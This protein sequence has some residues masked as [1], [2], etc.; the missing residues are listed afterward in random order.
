MGHTTQYVFSIIHK[1]IGFNKRFHASAPFH[2]FIAGNLDIIIKFYFVLSLVRIYTGNLIGKPPWRDMFVNIIYGTC[3]LM[4]ISGVWAINVP[5]S[6]I[7]LVNRLVRG[8]LRLTVFPKAETF[9]C[10]V[11]SLIVECVVGGWNVVGDTLV[12]PG[13]QA[14]LNCRWHVHPTRHQMHF[15]CWGQGGVA[16]AGLCIEKVTILACDVS[17]KWIQTRRCDAV[18]LSQLILSFFLLWCLQRESEH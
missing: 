3:W 16:W 14:C 18:L 9:S 7:C 1:G 17:W 2:L 6:A 13:H 4:R 12:V 5:E 15:N 11:S 8:P 10:L